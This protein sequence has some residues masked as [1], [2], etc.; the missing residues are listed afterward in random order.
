[1]DR[2]V[3]RSAAMKT[4]VSQIEQVAQTDATV[5]IQGE[6]GTGQ[7]LLTRAVHRLSARKDRPLVTVNCTALSPTLV[8]SEL[9]GCEKGAY[10]GALTR[11]T[12]LRG[13]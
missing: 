8:E 9:F 11:M 10:T 7:E 2:L 5:L 12:A 6:T 13:G 4:I 1:M 3:G